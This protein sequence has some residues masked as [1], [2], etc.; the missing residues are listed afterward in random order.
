MSHTVEQIA[1]EALSLPSEHALC[2]QTALLKALTPWRTAIYASFGLLKHA[3]AVMMSEMA[4]LKPYPVK[5][6]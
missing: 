6:H 2:L 4:W 1:D 3:P 5:R